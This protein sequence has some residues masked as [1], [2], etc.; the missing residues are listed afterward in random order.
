MKL[1]FELRQTHRVEFRKE[2]LPFRVGVAIGRDALLGED[3]AE[4][5]NDAAC[6]H[7]MRQYLYRSR[8]GF[9]NGIIKELK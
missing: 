9:P 5:Q 7:R 3:E 4:R 1:G 6:K 2:Q 8:V